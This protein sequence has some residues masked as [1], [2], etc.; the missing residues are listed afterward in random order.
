MT[1]H[2]LNLCRNRVG[3]VNALVMLIRWT[4][5]YSAT[6]IHLLNWQ[7]LEAII[8]TNLRKF[9]A[10]LKAVVASS[11]LH[12]MSILHAVVCFNP[13]ST[14]KL[15]SGFTPFSTVRRPP[16]FEVVKYLAMASPKSVPLEDQEDTSALEFAI[17][18]GT[19]SSIVKFLMHVTQTQS[20]KTVAQVLAVYDALFL[21]LGK[22]YVADHC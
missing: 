18:S 21:V 5:S 8:I 20:K 13:P 1:N 22:C 9:V 19:D 11:T 16:S 12:G 14:V 6:T 2:S 15:V 17:L 10:V 4:P 3:I 7:L